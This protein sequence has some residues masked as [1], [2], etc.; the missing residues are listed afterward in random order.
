VPGSIVYNVDRCV[1]CGICVTT[2]PTGATANPTATEEQIAGQ[3]QSMI[4]AAEQPVGIEFRCRDA[5]PASLEDGWYPLEVPCNGMLTIG[6]LLAPLVLGAGAVAAPPCK[7]TSC[8]VG[9]D[10]RLAAHVS[11]ALSVLGKFGVSQRRLLSKGVGTVPGPI[12]DADASP[13][14]NFNDTSVYLALGAVAGIA[15]AV[16]TSETGAVG[17]VTINELICTACEQCAEVCPS[18]ALAAHHHEETVEISFDPSLCVGCGMCVSTCPERERGAITLERNFDL[19]ELNLGSRLVLTGSTSMC[20]LCGDP[21]AP[22]AMLDRIHTMLG[23]EHARTLD[24][25]S[26]RCINCR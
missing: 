22:S 8:M 1:T 14:A 17:I 21:I 5:E 20:E 13:L 11:D 3:I 4:S 9:N 10:D 16:F 12:T 19:E 23:S 24:L 26:R 6:W 18:H 15:D 25:I 7:P 2:C